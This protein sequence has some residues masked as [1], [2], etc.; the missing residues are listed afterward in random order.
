MGARIRGVILVAL[1]L[2]AGAFAGSAISQWWQEGP[3]PGAVSGI[4]GTAA[5]LNGRVRVEVLNG[6]GRDGMARRAT[7]DL[8]DRGFDVV[9]FGNAGDFGRDS[10]V[11]L[12]RTGEVDWA[13]AVADALGIREVRVE[14]AEN[15]YLDVTVLLG[16]EWEPAPEPE[17]FPGDT[18]A[19]WWDPRSWFDRRPMAPNPD[20]HL[21]DPGEAGRDP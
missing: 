16:A 20:E 17:V 11:V 7:A 5:R 14:S 9:Y 15:L 21:V 13:R 4:P 6:G 19:P 3:R 2:T 8:R 10:S 12:A 18:A 1:L